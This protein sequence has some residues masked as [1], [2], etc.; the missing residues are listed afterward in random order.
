MNPGRVLFLVSDLYNWYR[1]HIL[2][3][4]RLDWAN[5]KPLFTALDTWRGLRDYSTA[6][7]EAVDSLSAN[8]RTEA[9]VDQ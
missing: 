3:T 7:I 4:F 1:T 9:P 6:P 2:L 8:Q 5:Q